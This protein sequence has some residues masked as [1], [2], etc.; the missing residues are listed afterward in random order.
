MIKSFERRSPGT[1]NL[2]LVG[3]LVDNI[4]AL[5]EDHEGPSIYFWSVFL[6]TT[7]EFLSVSDIKGMK[8]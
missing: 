8:N 5:V 1:F 2:F 3:V 4:R 6:L 7:L